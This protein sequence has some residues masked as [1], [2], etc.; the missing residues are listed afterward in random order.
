MVDEAWSTF[1]Y[2]HVRLTKHLSRAIRAM[3][4]WSIQASRSIVRLFPDC[5][6][7]KKHFPH[8]ILMFS[9]AQ[10]KWID[11]QRTLNAGCLRRFIGAWKIGQSFLVEGGGRC[12]RG[13]V[14]RKALRHTIDDH[15]TR[16]KRA[17]TCQLQIWKIK[18]VGACRCTLVS[19]LFSH[20]ISRVLSVH[21]RTEC[22]I[23][24]TFY[25][26]NWTFVRRPT[27]IFTGI[28]SVF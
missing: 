19:K 10:C 9:Y 6:L 3:S 27:E 26:N 21:T 8:H 2:F 17:S 20:H 28:Y 14:F 22:P 24:A 18:P 1:I 15:L 16:T 25:Q 12:C 4:G 11:P 23:I 7:N 13:W 5:R